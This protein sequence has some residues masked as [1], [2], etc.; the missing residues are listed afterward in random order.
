MVFNWRM[1]KWPVIYPYN[2]Y[3][4]NNKREWNPDMCNNMGDS[5]MLYVKWNKPN[6]KG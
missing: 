6:S 1:N 4:L 2:E 3:L 5:Q